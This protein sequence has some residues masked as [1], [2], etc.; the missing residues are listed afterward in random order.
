MV[1]V[2][3]HPDMRRTELLCEMQNRPSNDLGDVIRRT[4]N[5]KRS[6]TKKSS[7]PDLLPVCH[8]KKI[9]ERIEDPRY[10]EDYHLVKGTQQK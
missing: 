3:K 6:T 7:G 1:F 5:T 8:P 4:T 9:S 10:M 2:L